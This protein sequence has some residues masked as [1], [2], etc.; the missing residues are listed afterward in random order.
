MPEVKVSF[1]INNT[2]LYEMMPVHRL[3]EKATLQ[4]YIPAELYNLYREIESNFKTSFSENQITNF[5]KLKR[6][7][8]LKNTITKIKEIVHDHNRKISFFEKSNKEIGFVSTA[9]GV[10]YT[11]IDYSDE[12]LIFYSTSQNHYAIM[13]RLDR[14]V[15]RNFE[16]Y[17]FKS[18]LEGTA[19]DQD[20]RLII[21]KVFSEFIFKKVAKINFQDEVMKKI[22]NND[23]CPI[24]GKLKT[25]GF[26]FLNDNFAFALYELE[27]LSVKKTLLS[28]TEYNSAH[29]HTNNSGENITKH[30]PMI[31]YKYKIEYEKLDCDPIYIKIALLQD[32]TVE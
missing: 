20:E 26:E 2:V 8:T 18:K 12:S 21:P 24:I 28:E 7:Y 32:N 10:N 5:K 15:K 3:G 31:R 23:T 4:T 27:L 14:K 25:N 17:K 16:L 29:T 9:K 1:S 19:K 6:S 22:I 30:I 13:S 11:N